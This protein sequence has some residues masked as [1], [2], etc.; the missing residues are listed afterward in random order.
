M[1]TL[2]AFTRTL[3]TQAAVVVTVA[4]LAGC[5]ADPGTE[6]TPTS[7]PA[8]A[9]EAAAFAAAEETY[10]A[11]TDALNAV[12]LSDPSTFEATYV[13]TSG[14]FEASDKENLSEMH[15]KGYVIEGAT[16]VTQF[17]GTMTDRWREKIDATVCVDVSNVDVIDADGN[18]V[19]NPERPDVYAIATT[20]KVHGGQ[21]LIDHASRT[22]SSP[23]D[24]L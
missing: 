4:L 12:D 24:G 22:E 11:Y 3:P 6:P 17:L 23:C 15:A 5:A 7:T 13:Y 18:S 21:V 2:S 9:S 8:F 10:R 19:A 14:D 16:L 20:F 1:P